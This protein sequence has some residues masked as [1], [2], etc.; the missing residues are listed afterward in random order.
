MIGNQAS[1]LELLKK[2]FGYAIQRLEETDS[3]G[4]K[5]SVFAQ[6]ATLIFSDNS[7]LYVTEKLAKGKIVS[8]QYDWVN[9][10]GQSL[11]SYHSEAHDDEDYRTETEPYHAHPPQHA[12]LT[13]KTR[14]PNHAY[15]DLFSIVEGIFLF[16]ILPKKPKI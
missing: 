13:N 7:K 10:E 4:M 14:F 8:F 11:G 1:N 2:I 6:R 16:S 5:S 12:K 9:E 3:S 15:N